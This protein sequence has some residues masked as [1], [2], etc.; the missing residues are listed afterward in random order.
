MSFDAF[1]EAAKKKRNPSV[2]G[3]D[4]KIEYVPDFLKQGVSPAEAL[5]EFN[6]GL[7]D[8]CADLIAAVKPQSAFY[9]IYG[10]AGAAALEKTIKYA[11]SA[12]LYVI[13]DAKRGDIGSTAQAYAEAY[14]GPDSAGSDCMTVNAYLG[15]DGIKPFANIAA[16]YD[17]ALFILVK[18][19]NPSSAEFQDIICEDGKPLYRLVGEK[20]ELWGGDSI[21]S[22]GYS[23]IGAV[24]GA[25]Y[26]RQVAELR[27]AMPHTFF[28]IPGYGAQGGSAADAALAF[29]NGA[30]AAVNSSRGLMCAYQKKGDPINYKKHTREA[31]IEM[32]D[33]LA[34]VIGYRV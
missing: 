5:L 15:W 14:L 10:A 20:A 29:K 6:R 17:K 7:I 32:R 28:L 26:P 27:E 13:L 4:P 3:L 23:R 34:E 9:E 30:G 11:K 2:L 33:A 19:S 8:C 21:G 1:I 12:G 16:K 22:Y 25:T 18:T 24:V 31:V